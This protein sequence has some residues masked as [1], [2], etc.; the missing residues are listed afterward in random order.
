VLVL[1]DGSD[2]MIANQS[3]TV[4]T[5]ADGHP[6]TGRAAASERRGAAA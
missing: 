5:A 3:L 1:I 2:P 6:A 4:A